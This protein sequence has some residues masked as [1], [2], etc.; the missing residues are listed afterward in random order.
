M[1]KREFESL[2]ILIIVLL[3]AVPGNTYLPLLTGSSRYLYFIKPILWA[4]LSFYVWK[5][6]RIRFKGKLRLYGYILV[7]SAICG[8]VYLAAFFSGGFLDGIGASPYAKDLLGIAANVV[9]FG[10][11]LVM[12]EWVRNYVVNRVKRRYVLLFSAITVL[13]FSLCG[14]NLRII[15]SLRSWRT[16]VQYIGE[17]VLPEISMNIF[18]TYLVYIG[19]AYPAMICTALT[20]LPIW[21]SPVLPDLEWITMAFIGIMLPMV[22]LVVVRQIYRKQTKEIKIREQNQDKPHAWIATSV[23][24]I[25]IIWFAV[26][27]FPVF[28]TV[29]LTGSME[30]SLKPGDVALIQKCD[31]KNLDVGSV[32]QYWT[33]DYFIIH[34]IESIDEK[35]GK[36]QTKGDNNS[37]PDSRLVGPG[38]VRGKMIA[39]V[40]KLGML[41]I[42]LRTENKGWES[43]VEF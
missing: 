5:M 24:A 29:I 10:G 31:G 33:G 25:A 12:M 8:I 16:V 39:S 38:Q 34:R 30:P 13:V 7:W 2:I 27:V 36:Y 37:A 42:L 32:I 22:F 19:G 6:P 28:P 17:Y 20:S 43:E 35:S 1:G 15:F 4:V 41:T 11:V 23:L 9:C 14:I 40:P 26:G 21:I 3:I 18:L